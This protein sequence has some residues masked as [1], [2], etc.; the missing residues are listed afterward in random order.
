MLKYDCR[1]LRESYLSVP[2]GDACKTVVASEV[3]SQ[4]VKWDHRMILK[5]QWL[6]L[7]L[8]GKTLSHKGHMGNKEGILTLLTESY[9]WW[10][11]GDR[12]REGAGYS[13]S[14]CVWAR[15]QAMRVSS[16]LCRFQE[17]N[18]SPQAWLASSLT[19]WTILLAQ[20]R[21][22]YCKFSILSWH[23]V[24]YV[25]VWVN[26][27]PTLVVPVLILPNSDSNFSVVLTSFGLKS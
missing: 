20:L 22:F 9:I 3:I 1:L 18:S 6:P 26:P 17:L 16:L 23:V 7:Q 4:M 13:T 15:R 2:A 10:W 12:E 24:H 14:E 11:G 25:S 19:C 21:C 8:M 5:V 27:F